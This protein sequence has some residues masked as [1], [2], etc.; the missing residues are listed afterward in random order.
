M[1]VFFRICLIVLVSFLVSCAE[2]QDI[3]QALEDRV[4]S[5]HKKRTDITIERVD[6]EDFVLEQRQF[7]VAWLYE[8][9]GYDVKAFQSK[10]TAKSFSRDELYKLIKRAY[11]P[12]DEEFRYTHKRAAAHALSNSIYRHLAANPYDPDYADTRN[13]LFTPE[14]MDI[15]IAETPKV[16]GDVPPNI[17]NYYQLLFNAFRQNIDTFDYLTMQFKTDPKVLNYIFYKMNS[18][19]IHPNQKVAIQYATYEQ[20]KEYLSR[21]GLLLEF[22]NA[23]YQDNSE[24]V[25]TAILQNE[26]A[27]IYASPRLRRIIETSGPEKL[28]GVS[29]RMYLAKDRVSQ[30]VSDI[31][32]VVKVHSKQYSRK[33][34]ELTTSTINK[35]RSLLFNEDIEEDFVDEVAD[36]EE[37][38]ET[39]T[40]LPFTEDDAIMTD[41]RLI[42]QIQD[43]HKRPLR[44]L[45]R[46]AKIDRQREIYIAYF[47]PQGR[48]YLASIVYRNGDQFVMSDYKA[49]LTTDGSTIWR[50]N[51]FGKF[52][53]TQI[54]II[55]IEEI[56]TKELRVKIKWKGNARSSLYLLVEKNGKFVKR[57]LSHVEEL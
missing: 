22:V 46:I 43:L 49:S 29:A 7:D 3:N 24:L 35:V 57:F 53:P 34:A 32:Y 50:Y 19:Y 54:Q 27:E 2:D 40:L 10:V 13:I 52:D 9:T 12:H 55:D 5:F 47:Q 6:M 39:R 41:P 45:W 23:D 30:E 1:S 16:L 4:N 36:L 44:Y 37:L 38:E 56:K 42:I 18:Q 28:I 48:R 17:S 21:N 31:W 25:Y 14:F 26:M 15:M 8:R 33:V 11:V 20:A 51:D